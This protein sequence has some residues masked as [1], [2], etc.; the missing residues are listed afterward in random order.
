MKIFLIGYRA[1][2]KSTVGL[3]LSKSLNLP[4]ADIDHAIESAAGMTIKELIARQGWDAFR[5]KETETIAR[6]RDAHSCVV[7]TGGGAVLSEANRTMLK[8]MGKMIYL[9]TPLD[10]IVER[11]EQDAGG[12]ATRPQFTS[13]NLAAETIAVL[14]Q[15]I[16]LY[17]SVADFTVDT[18]GKS[19]IQVNNDIYQL[20][21]EAGIVA[22]IE[23][24][25]KQQRQK[26]IGG[27]GNGG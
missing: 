2:G 25:R 20:L 12:K 19:I 18:A 26:E 17:E 16:P 10:R 5:K 8:E 4:F 14:A 22:D 3:L 21:L 24:I 9:K 7:A 23:K 11:L 6:L 15:R 27:G 13:E 1:S